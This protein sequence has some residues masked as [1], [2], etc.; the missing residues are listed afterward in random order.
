MS[1]SAHSSGTSTPSTAGSVLHQ[2]ALYD[3]LVWVLTLG[4]ER[5]F[6]EKVVQVAGLKPGETVLEVG[7]GTGTLAIAA[8][9]AVGLQGTVHGIDASPEMTARAVRKA[10]KAGLQVDF[11]NAVAEALPF[12]DEQFDVV[13]A[14]MMLH[15]LPS[16]VRRQCFAEIRRVL[17][18]GGRFIAVDFGGP[19]RQRRGLITHFHRHVRFDLLELVPTLA[20]VGLKRVESGAVGFSDLQFVLAARAEAKA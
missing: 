16:D 11:K 18:P 5:D 1:I 17:K 7:S 19:Q 20:E 9:R 15:H 4:R 6:R 2:A 14:S 12:P 8:K 3:F 10:T 13:L